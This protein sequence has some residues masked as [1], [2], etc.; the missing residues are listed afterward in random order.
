[1]LPYG[2][3]HNSYGQHSVLFL[4][5]WP[6]GLALLDL[7]VLHWEGEWV[8]SSSKFIA[9]TFLP[10]LIHDYKDKNGLIE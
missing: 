3:T 4:E 5:A 2:Y 9:F 8:E 10:N 7:T 6:Y 1:M